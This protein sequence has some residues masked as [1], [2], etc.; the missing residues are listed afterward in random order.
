M[1]RENWLMQA[2]GELRPL[3]EAAGH[4][5]PATVRVTCGF[6]STARR[7]GTLG[8]TWSAADSADGATEVMI[9]PVLAAG[10]DVLAVLLAQLS[11][12]ADP[13][14]HADV[15]AAVGTDP[16]AY[17]GLLADLGPYPHAALALPVKTTQA[18]RMLKACCPS[19]G[20]TVRLTQKWVSK[21]LPICGT[22]GEGFKLEGAAA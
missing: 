16:A 1:N 17:A 11:V 8:E 4:P 15:K 3:F 12:A 20:Y 13:R 9:S 10:A 2:V 22:C 6:P 5:L 14:R 21:G 18:T 7:S 19:C